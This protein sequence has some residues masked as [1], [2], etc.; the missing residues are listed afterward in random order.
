MNITL[1]RVEGVYGTPPE[2]L[3]EAKDRQIVLASIVLLV[4]SPAKLTE[5]RVFVLHQLLAVW[6]VTHALFTPAVFPVFSFVH[7]FSLWRGC[8]W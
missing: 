6:S 4:A 1:D 5:E 2:A 8:L 7:T 3:V